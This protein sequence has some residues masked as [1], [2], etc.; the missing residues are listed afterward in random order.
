MV[1][2]RGIGCE[3]NIQHTHQTQERAQA[4][5]CITNTAQEHKTLPELTTAVVGQEGWSSGSPV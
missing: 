1:F 2:T 3:Q 4:R 5:T